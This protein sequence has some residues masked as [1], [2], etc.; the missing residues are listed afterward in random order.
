MLADADAAALGREILAT[1]DGIHQQW[2]LDPDAVDL[3]AALSAYERRLRH[4]LAASGYPVEAI[5]L[6]IAAA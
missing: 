1:P 2:L 5:S 3:T 6:T 4:A